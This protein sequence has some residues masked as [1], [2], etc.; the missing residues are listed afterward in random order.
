[1]RT[2]VLLLAVVSLLAAACG[3]DDG[4][5][6]VPTQE[7]ASPLPT[8]TA[9]TAASPTPTPL[10]ATA[11]ALTVVSGQNRFVPTVAEFAQLPQ[12]EI[13]LPGGEIVSGVS[14]GDLAALV[15]AKEG[16]IV[17]VEGQQIGADLTGFMREPLADVTGN[18]VIY[19]TDAGQ[20]MLA[21]SVL[22]KL[23]WLT[24]VRS[25]TFE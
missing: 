11:N 20:L 13:E 7:P 14:I 12:T 6:P 22:P 18:V 19:L 5:E 17:T 9:T 8:A 4:A 25:V 2:M 24:A 23:E 16:G 3:G 1:M 15:D 10:P 21:G